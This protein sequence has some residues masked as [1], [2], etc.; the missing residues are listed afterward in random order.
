MALDMQLNLTPQAA[1]DV[2][3]VE[4][5]HYHYKMKKEPLGL[6]QS[7]WLFKIIPR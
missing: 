6:I 2:L 7:Q 5:N 4:I 1:S 3:S